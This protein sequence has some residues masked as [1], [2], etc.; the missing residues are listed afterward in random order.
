MR[1]LVRVVFLGFDMEQ[2]TTHLGEP[3][4]HFETHHGFGSIWAREKRAAGSLPCK[5]YPWTRGGRNW[6]MLSLPPPPPIIPL[7]VHDMF[8]HLGKF[9]LSSSFYELTPMFARQRFRIS[10]LWILG[11]C[12]DN[13]RI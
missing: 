6:L 3:S 7:K 5:P 10:G 4:T 13:M 1:I 12:K 9:L 8:E 2:A 11:I